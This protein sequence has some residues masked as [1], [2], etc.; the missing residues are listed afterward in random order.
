M[1]VA[2]FGATGQTGSSFVL[3]ALEKAKNIKMVACVRNVDKM[4]EILDKNNAQ[5]CE[6]HLEIVKVDIF[7]P[8]SIRPHLEGVEV[9]VSGLG[10]EVKR[11]QTW[12]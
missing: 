12:V 10:F 1:K 2:V 3:Q 5:N 11:P 4:K 9:V 8:E 7:D 6:D